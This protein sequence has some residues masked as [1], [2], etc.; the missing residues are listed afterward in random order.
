M[1]ESLDVEY[2]QTF[3]NGEYGPDHSTREEMKDFAW[4]QVRKQSNLNKFS[5]AANYLL[6]YIIAAHYWRARE[7]IEESK[8]SKSLLRKI[9]GKKYYPGYT[10]D[11]DHYTR[12][13]LWANHD[14]RDLFP[15][16]VIESMKSDFFYEPEENKH[17][18]NG[19][20]CY[21]FSDE[22]K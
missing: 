12:H 20:S 1:E 16:E 5:S 9:R 19:M 7:H 11:I 3:Q 21:Q 17:L 15:I 13:W 4:R 10:L 8:N 18:P 22:K 14:R 6:H 2:T